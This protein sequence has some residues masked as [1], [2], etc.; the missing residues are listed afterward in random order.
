MKSLSRIPLFDNMFFSWSDHRELDALLEAAVS[1]STD[2]KQL[3]MK[4]SEHRNLLKDSNTKCSSML[5][6]DCDQTV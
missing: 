6:R 2:L 3:K 1:D 4:V 5:L